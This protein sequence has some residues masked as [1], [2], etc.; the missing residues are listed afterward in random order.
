MRFA[1]YRRGL[2]ICRIRMPCL[3]PPAMNAPATCDICNAHKAD[4]SGAFRV[5]PPLWQEFVLDS[6]VST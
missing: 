4:T 6:P 1:D 5:P 3:V 2:R